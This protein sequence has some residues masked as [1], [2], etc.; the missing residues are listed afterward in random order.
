[1][2]LNVDDMGHFSPI[3]AHTSQPG[4]PD[5][6]YTIRGVNGWL[7]L[8]WGT[9]A[10]PP[11]LR[12]RQKVWIERNIKHGGCPLV[13]CGI[14]E[15][16]DKKTFGLIKGRRVLKCFGKPGIK[17]WLDS[18]SIAWLGKVVW[19]EFLTHLVYPEKLQ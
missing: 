6:A 7:E 12:P 13:F 16:D 11:E 19:P 4:V 10:K 8:K 2:L 14:Q 1:M 17:P 3:E 15:P 9:S 18:M 5:F